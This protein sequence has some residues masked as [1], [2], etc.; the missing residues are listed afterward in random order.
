MPCG[1]SGG[2]VEASGNS[3]SGCGGRGLEPAIAVG[4]KG[5][6]CYLPPIGR[7]RGPPAAEQLPAFL[8]RRGLPDAEAL[9]RGQGE[10]QTWLPGR[11][12]TAERLG[13]LSLLDG[14]P[15]LPQRI[16][17]VRILLAAEPDVSP[18]ETSR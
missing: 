6:H 13:H 10:G 2:S 5:L 16:E 11:A 18:S 17:E 7:N 12:D 9:V 15:A 1:R 4:V 3:D 14:V 8:W